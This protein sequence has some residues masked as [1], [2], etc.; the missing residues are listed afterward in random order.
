MKEDGEGAM[1]TIGSHTLCRSLLEARLVDR[2]R[3]V[4]YAPT[5]MNGPPGS[6]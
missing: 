5:V 4:K 1:R 6:S 3:V 2:F